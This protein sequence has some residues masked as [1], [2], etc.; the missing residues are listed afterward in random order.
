[1]IQP[2]REP[3]DDALEWRFYFP[4]LTAMIRIGE[5]RVDSPFTVCELAQDR[6]V[7]AV[8]AERFSPAETRLIARVFEPNAARLPRVLGIPDA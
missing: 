4:K 2:I 5:R 1:M 7:L 3:C 8:R 6:P